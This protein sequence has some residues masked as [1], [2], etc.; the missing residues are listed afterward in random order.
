MTSHRWRSC[1]CS[2]LGRPLDS[3]VGWRELR[4]T[5]LTQSAALLSRKSR[6]TFPYSHDLILQFSHD[7][8]LPYFH[9]LIIPSPSY[10]GFEGGSCHVSKLAGTSSVR[11]QTAWSPRQANQ[12]IQCR[13]QPVSTSSPSSHHHTLPRYTWFTLET[14][15][16]SWQNLQTLVQSKIVM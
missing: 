16:E 12:V 11:F 3:M 8:I 6:H 10:A 1:T 4:R 13:Q 9:D 2:L 15:E 5:S 7:L 14:L